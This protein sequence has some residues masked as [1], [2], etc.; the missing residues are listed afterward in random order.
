MPK[1][2]G[3][4]TRA[5][6]V[7]AGLVLAGLLAL[8]GSQTWWHVVV[9]PAQQLDVPG[10][11][12]A[13]ALLAF[14]MGLLALNAALAL[15]GPI[16]AR[17]LSVF[18]ILFGLCTGLQLW[19]AVASPILAAKGVLAEH[20]GISGVAQLREMVKSMAWTPYI[21]LTGVVALA[22][23]AHGVLGLIKSARFTV[24]RGYRR[25]TKHEP[26]ATDD[27]SGMWDA[28]TSGDDPTGTSTQPPG[29]NR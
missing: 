8:V 19:I 25:Q 16:A 29:S 18:E 22:I 2:V 5:K 23:I 9:Q 17:V 3:T 24:T 1:F 12:A 11:K 21:V 14:T 10:S 13:P 26:I 20:T 7:L 4:W 15:S 6:H 28:I 27:A